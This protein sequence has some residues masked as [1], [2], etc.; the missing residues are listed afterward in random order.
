MGKSW[1]QAGYLSTMKL[2]LIVV[3]FVVLPGVSAIAAQFEPPTTLN[4]SQILPPDLLSGPNHCVEERVYNDGYL[5]TYR[6]GSKFGTFVAVST[7]MLRKR[8]GEI[9]ALVRMEQIQ[10][11]KE[12]MTSIKEAGMDTL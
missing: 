6:V 3:A 9:N 11:S 7:S 8:I 4:A 10:N 2:V 5:N 12:F 1:N